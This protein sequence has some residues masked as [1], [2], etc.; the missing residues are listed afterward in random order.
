[1]KK[2]FRTTIVFGLLSS[3]MMFPVV[4]YAGIR[5]GWPILFELVLWANVAVYAGLM[6]GW[7]RVRFRN[8]LFPLLLLLGVA[9]LP[10][11]HDAFILIALG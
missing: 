8:A 1:M 4:W 3:L 6:C 9:F 5:Y 10:I 2:P 11:R 7:S